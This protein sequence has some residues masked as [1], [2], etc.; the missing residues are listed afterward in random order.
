MGLVVPPVSELPLSA[1]EQASLLS[2]GSRAGRPRGNL[3][4]ALALG[5]G[6]VLPSKETRSLSR[7]A[8]GA[9]WQPVVPGRGARGAVDISGFQ[10]IKSSLSPKGKYSL[11]L[12]HQG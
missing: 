2:A 4:V 6:L 7:A 1:P 8:L 5:G 9:V 10:S 11:L 3:D 12:G